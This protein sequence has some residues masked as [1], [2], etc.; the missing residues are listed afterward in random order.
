MGGGA[1]VPLFGSAHREITE[2]N[3]GQISPNPTNSDQVAR[4][5]ALLLDAA[6][7]MLPTPYLGE[8]VGGLGKY[9]GSQSS[10]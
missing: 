1:A 8:G 3:K 7:K 10:I 5:G 6:A 9:S 4:F 2:T